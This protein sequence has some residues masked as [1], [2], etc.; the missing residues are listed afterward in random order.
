MA[1]FTGGISVN[2]AICVYSSSSDAVSSNFFEA[3]RALG[4]E[5][6]RREHPLVYGGSDVGLMGAIARSVHEHGGKVIG[7]IPEALLDWGVAYKDADELIVTKGMR[8]RKAI[9]E[10]RAEAFVALPGGFGTLE[11][12]FEILTLKQLQYHTKPIALLD[13][14]GFYEPFNK[15]CEHMYE[16]KFAQPSHRQLYRVTPDIDSLFAY[17]ETYQPPTPAVKWTGSRG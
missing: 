3:A 16:Q 15:L 14:D 4:A 6:A 12:V 9:M 5:M 7:V 11:E 1:C 2:K 17:L 8:E 13:V 10:E